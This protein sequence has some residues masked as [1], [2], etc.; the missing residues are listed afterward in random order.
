IRG[1]RDLVELFLLESSEA[2]GFLKGCDQG[3]ATAL[4]LAAIEGHYDIVK[5][6]LD[7]GAPI[8]NSDQEGRPPLMWASLWGHY[9]T[10]QLLV[11]RSA[12]Q[13]LRDIDG[14]TAIDLASPSERNE[15]E[16]HNDPDYK[17]W[18]E[19]ASTTRKII[20]NS[21]TSRK[22]RKLKSHLLVNDGGQITMPNPRES[23]EDYAFEI[24]SQGNFQRQ[25]RLSKIVSDFY[26][27][28]TSKTIAVLKRP[29][30]CPDVAA[31]SGWKHEHYFTKDMLKLRGSWTEVALQTGRAIGYEFPP[32]PDKDQGKPG[33]YNACHAEAKLIA[34]MV[35]KHAFLPSEIV[36]WE[37]LHELVNV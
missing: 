12:K 32:S 28:N 35:S 4:G 29:G 23:P 31:M 24:Q 11:H 9:S 21:P 5:L 1:N 19:E 2:E 8:N 27:H 17:G 14:F 6:L 7:F 25:I 22:A 33:Q 36:K 37:E 26:P 34:F 18:T 30:I 10:M 15:N 20:V 3:G 16:R 13:G